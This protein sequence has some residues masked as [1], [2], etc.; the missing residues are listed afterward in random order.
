MKWFVS[1]PHIGHENMYTHFRREDG[2]PARPFV[3]AEEFDKAFIAKCLVLVRPG[4]KIYFMGDVAMG[5][6]ERSLAVLKQLKPLKM[7]LIL[8]NHDKTKQLALYQE[9]F[10]EICS[11]KHFDQ[12]VLTHVPIHPDCLGRW[13]TNVHGHLHHNRIRLPDGTIDARY[14]NVSVECTDYAPISYD[15]LRRRI[16]LGL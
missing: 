6:T 5:N 1:D 2:S 7:D 13:G 12:I 15:E 10:S 11:I 16:T 3:S 14:Q 8:G 9:V 4:D